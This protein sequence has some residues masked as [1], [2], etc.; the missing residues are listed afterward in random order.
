MSTTG[1]VLKSRGSEKSK[2]V[3]GASSSGAGVGQKRKVDAVE[4]AAPTVSFKTITALPT[5]SIPATTTGDLNSSNKGMQLLHKFGWEKGTAIGKSGE[6]ANEPIKV[7]RIV[8]RA[9]IGCS[10]VGAVNTA[11][12]SGVALLIDEELDSEKT[13]AWK[14]MMARFAEPR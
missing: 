4:S 9:G 12:V 7:S 2:G 10:S 8:D 3:V 1:Q 14:R 13:K 6:K 11:D 5:Q